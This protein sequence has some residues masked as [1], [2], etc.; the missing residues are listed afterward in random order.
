ML[1]GV[2]LVG[3]AFCWWFKGLEEQRLGFGL[4][5]WEIG[6][7][8]G[9]GRW[10]W[11]SG[12]CRAEVANS[13]WWWPTGGVVLK[14]GTEGLGFRFLFFFFPERKG[15]KKKE[16]GNQREAKAET[17]VR[18]GFASVRIKSSHTNLM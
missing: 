2:A 8:S 10:Q 9:D 3:V 14:A 4:A 17:P 16:K 7:A 18:K 12:G 11:R 6:E 1:G 13:W 15:E 5:N